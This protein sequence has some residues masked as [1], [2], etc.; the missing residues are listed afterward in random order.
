MLNSYFKYFCKL[1]T[2]IFLLLFLLFFLH[3]D[4]ESSEQSPALEEKSTQ[5]K[6]RPGLG[7]VPQNEPITTDQ[8]KQREG[9]HE[10]EGG[11]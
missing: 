6:D 4:L 9:D 8:E 3:D 1:R 7:S 2:Q 10:R 11:L 5:V